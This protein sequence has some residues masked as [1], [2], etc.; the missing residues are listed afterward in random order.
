MGSRLEEV[1][2][3]VTILT[4]DL[5]RGAP[6]QQLPLPYLLSSQEPVRSE[7]GRDMANHISALSALPKPMRDCGRFL[8][9]PLKLASRSTRISARGAVPF[10]EIP[11]APDALFLHRGLGITHLPL[12]STLRT[13]C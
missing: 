9:W 5:V 4:G 12:S 8:R 1:F 7:E 3:I 13:P 6:N 11:M 10:S 2:I